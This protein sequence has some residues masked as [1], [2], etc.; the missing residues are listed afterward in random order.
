MSTI[1]RL[2]LW[3]IDHTLVDVG[4]VTREAYADAF[5]RVTGRQ[6]VTLAATAG[7]S[8]SEIIFETLAFNDVIT[9]DEHLPKFI[10]ALA[11]AFRVRQRDVR[12]HGRVLP[13]AREALAGVDRQPGVVQSVLTGSIRP[14]AIVK[15]TELRLDQYVDFEVGGYGSESYPKSALI[16]LARSR[17]AEKYIEKR[18]GLPIGEPATVLIADSPR[19]VQAAQIARIKVIAVATGTANE[20]AL[21]AAG[22]DLV[23]PTLA[24]TQTVIRAIGH[25]TTPS[26]A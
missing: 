15:L 10:A 23:L 3:N 14:N 9:D 17:T 13:G 18:F 4:R 2:V 22:A 24:D 11:E 6:L 7:R 5:R 8:E 19:D 1:Q 20:A 16:G 25:F 26:A 21:R 12:T